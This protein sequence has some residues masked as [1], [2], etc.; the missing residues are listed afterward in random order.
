MWNTARKVARK[1]PGLEE[2]GRG[3]GSFVPGATCKVWLDADHD[4]P[5]AMARGKLSKK[6]LTG[7]DPHGPPAASDSCLIPGRFP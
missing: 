7:T 1:P 3:A 2:L 5:K 4:N 6:K